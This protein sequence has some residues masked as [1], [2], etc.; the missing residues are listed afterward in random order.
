M[1]TFD[2]ATTVRESITKL[3]TIENPL[4]KPVQILPEHIVCDTDAITFNPTSFTIQPFS[5]INHSLGFNS[6][7]ILGIWP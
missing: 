3:I 2:L 7:L 1:D 6:P 5:V 4:S